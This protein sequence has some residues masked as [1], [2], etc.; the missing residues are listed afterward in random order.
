MLYVRMVGKDPDE[1]Y[2]IENPSYVLRQRNGIIVRHP[3]GNRVQGVVSPDGSEIWQLSDRVSLGES[4]PV[5]ERITMAEYDEW[6]AQQ[7]QLEDTDPEDTEPV[8][9]EGTEESSILTRAE[10]TEKV[11]EL[12]EALN[13][14][15]SGVTEDG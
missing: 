4:Y 7:N 10:L 5:V 11:I 6:Y 12:D 13:L 8:I 1:L 3:E 14:L 2:A 9:P 15:L